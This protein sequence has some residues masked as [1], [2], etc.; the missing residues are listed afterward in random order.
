MSIKTIQVLLAEGDPE[1]AR[2][3]HDLLRRVPGTELLHVRTLAEALACL[4][5]NPVDVVL[6]NP[7]IP[8]APGPQAISM[9]QASVRSL[10][11]LVLADPGDERTA[12]EWVRAGAQDYLIKSQL[13]ARRLRRAIRNAAERAHGA[14]ALAQSEM[15]YR[16]LFEDASDAILIADAETGTILEANK[17]AERLLGRSRQELIGIDRAAL[18]PP[19]GVHTSEFSRHVQMDRVREA[20]TVLLHRDGRQIP[21]MVS[22]STFTIEGRKVIQRVFR[23]LSGLRRAQEEL[24]SL[25][26][27]PEENPSPVLRASVDGTLLYANSSSAPL[28]RHWACQPGERLPEDQALLVAGAIER[29]Q[30]LQF[31]LALPDRIYELTV[32]PLASEGRANLYGHDI[33]AHKHAEAARIESEANLQLAL[34]A[35]HTGAWTLNPADLTFQQTQEFDRILGHQAPLPRWTFPLFL[36]Q[37]LPEDRLEMVRGFETAVATGARW[38]FWCR[39]R[40]PDGEIRWL[41]G[42]SSPRQVPGGPRVY[43]GLVRDVTE[44][45]RAD[46][47]RT[48]LEEQLRASQ[49]M[50]AIGGLAGGIAH[51]FNNLLSVILSYTSFALESAPE[52]TPLHEDLCEVRKAGERAAALVRQLL[53]FSRKQMLQPKVLSLNQVLAEFHKMLLRIMGEDIEFVDELA[54]DLGLT[55]ADPSQIEQVIMNLVVNARDAMPEGGRLTMRTA[56]ATLDEEGSARLEVRPGPYVTLSIQDTGTGMTEETRARLFEPFFTTKQKGTGLGLPTVYGIVRQS[57]GAV[58]VESRL[59]QGATFR[60]WLPRLVSAVLGESPPEGAGP[61]PKGAETIL[62]VEDERA[63]RNLARR[64]LMAAGYSVLV[65]ESAQEALTLLQ[66]SPA[67]PDLVLTDVVMPGMKGTEFA[68]SLLS[69]NPGLRILFMSGYSEPSALQAD[70]PEWG[71]RFISK[72]FAAED[73]IR[74]VREVLDGS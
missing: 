43:S 6:L 33:T 36:E 68:R 45:K 16:V 7:R 31:E 22:A 17:A 47:E 72:P 38:S 9:L 11:A 53:A 73:L 26:R 63:V 70:Q 32:C 12:L 52:G 74:K 14:R 40:R 65:A 61:T 13:S 27:F 30:I 23:D 35:T 49:R 71:A 66:E 19:Q 21:A 29:D 24:E 3:V 28:L 44:R 50:E 58:E 2:L 42:L 34:E 57:G 51:D 5:S 64:V 25:S 62:V 41:R 10:Q 15:R 59:G 67:E 37:V 18:H 4:E 1:D 48:R 54:P 55:L 60:I 39:I 56:N 69:S 46:E 20:E 8:D